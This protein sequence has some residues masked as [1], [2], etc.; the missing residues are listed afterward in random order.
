MTVENDAGEVELVQSEV[1]TEELRYTPGG[2][3]SKMVDLVTNFLQSHVKLQD[4][5]MDMF[6]M[7]DNVRCNYRELI[8]AASKCLHHI[9]N[10]DP[11]I[12]VLLQHQILQLRVK[13]HGWFVSQRREENLNRIKSECTRLGVKF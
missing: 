3:N 8:H 6:K 2:D 11:E 9:K 7:Q 5:F 13:Y 12:D 4:M 10:A 1:R